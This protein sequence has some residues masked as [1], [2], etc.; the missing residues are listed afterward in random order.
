MSEEGHRGRGNPA[1]K[2]WEPTDF[3]RG[4]VKAWAEAGYTQ[5]D[6]ASRMDVDPKTLRAHCREELDFGTMDL[7]ADV[8]QQLGRLAKGAPA[9]FDE[10]QN[11]VRAEI[12]PNLGAICFLL[13]TKGKRLGWS[14]RLELTGKDGEALLPDLSGLT[15]EQI[16]VIATAQR[17]IASLA[18]A[19]ANPAGDRKT[20]H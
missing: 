13:K 9:Q 4:Q 16:E 20:T 18:P 1:W 7:L 15:D 5:E 10:N 14:E 12:P 2:P 6:I 3:Q 11:L 19:A 8:V 17:L